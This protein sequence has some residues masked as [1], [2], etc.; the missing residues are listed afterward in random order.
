MLGAGA[1]V[2]RANEPHA[3][4]PRTDTLTRGDEFV[5]SLVSIRS[6][7]KNSLEVRRYQV[8]AACYDFSLRRL[9]AKAGIVMSAWQSAVY[10]P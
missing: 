1:A 10:A 6:D 9:L 4:A 5:M 8:A 3:P 7:S 2:S